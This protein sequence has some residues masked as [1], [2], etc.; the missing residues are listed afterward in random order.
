M[1]GSFF[2][3]Y[4]DLSEDIAAFATDCGA[5]A[6]LLDGVF[7]DPSVSVSEWLD[8]LALLRSTF[9]GMIEAR[10]DEGLT[11]PMYLVH[12][13]GAYIANDTVRFSTLTSSLPAHKK[14]VP[15]YFTMADPDRYASAG[16]PWKP[17]LSTS[18]DRRD[19]I[20]ALLSSSNGAHPPRG[21]VLSGKAITDAL[22]SDNEP[23]NDI[24]SALRSIRQ[25]R[26]VED[27]ERGKV[28]SLR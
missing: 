3:T 24:T 1:P 2:S 15:M 25:R 27:L 6:L 28:E 18:P 8:L 12:I 16:E 26:L 10:M 19:A 4:R 7:G 20:L 11:P 17:V 21:I 23:G 5:D 22:L 13:D 9:P 14:D